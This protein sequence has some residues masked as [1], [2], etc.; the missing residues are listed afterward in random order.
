MSPYN[1]SKVAKDPRDVEYVLAISRLSSFVGPINWSDPYFQD[2]GYFRPRTNSDI[3]YE[4]L[5]PF[6]VIREVLFD[7]VDVTGDVEEKVTRYGMC[8]TW[9]ADGSVTTTST[10]NSMNF[11]AFLNVNNDQNYQSI[12]CSK[13]LKAAVHDPGE[14]P[15]IEENGFLVPPGTLALATLSIT[16]HSYLGKPFIAFGDEYCVDTASYGFVNSV[17]PSPYS[18]NAC[19]QKCKADHTYQRC[20]CVPLGS[21]DTTFSSIPKPCYSPQ[22]CQQ[23]TYDVRVSYALFPSEETGSFMESRLG[24]STEYIRENF[25]E[26]HIYFDKMKVHDVKQVPV[27]ASEKDTLS[28]IG[29]QMGLLLGASLLSL[30]EIFEFLVN[31][32]IYLIK[33]CWKRIACTTNVWKVKDAGIAFEN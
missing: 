15:A 5:N 1:R 26:V 9:N 28:N 10:G 31:C 16:T 3:K 22:P 18:M 23:T 20:G 24:V 19:N 30:L 33:K 2:N 14:H 8:Y 12:D 29:G 25:K 13:G 6:G 17:H 4:S 7:K 32:V 21:I 11:V 27:Y